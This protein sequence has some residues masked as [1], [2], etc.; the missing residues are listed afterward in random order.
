MQKENINIMFLNVK[1]KLEA[2]DILFFFF[3]FFFFF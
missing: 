2:D 3:L 1:T